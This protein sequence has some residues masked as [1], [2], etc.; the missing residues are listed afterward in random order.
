V[1]GNVLFTEKAQRFSQEKLQN[2]KGI[3]NK[4]CTAHNGLVHEKI[5]TIN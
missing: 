1:P 4:M 2:G 3:L 5:N